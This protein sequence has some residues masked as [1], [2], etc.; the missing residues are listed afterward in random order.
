L[1]KPSA[2]HLDTLNQASNRVYRK[3]VDRHKKGGFGGAP[4][5]SENLRGKTKG[6]KVTNSFEKAI[7]QRRKQ[8]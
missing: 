1:E 6:A 7:S 2:L 4:D 8:R 3:E 5:V